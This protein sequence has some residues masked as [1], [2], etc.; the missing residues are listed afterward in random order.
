VIFCASINLDAIKNIL[1][2][3][4]YLYQYC[5]SG[6][7]KDRPRYLYS[8]DYK[9][10]WTTFIIYFHTKSVALHNQCSFCNLTLWEYWK[11]PIFWW[12]CKNRN[13]NKLFL[14]YSSCFFLL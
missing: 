3:L 5:V 7:V 14:L 11:T 2:Y 12:K 8:Y 1:I 6:G 13:S 4:K 9:T 10:K